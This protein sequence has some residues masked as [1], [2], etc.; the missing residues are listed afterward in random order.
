MRVSPWAFVLNWIYW[1]AVSIIY[2]KKDI[3]RSKNMLKHMFFAIFSFLAF[4][5]VTFWF[6]SYNWLHKNNQKEFRTFITISDSIFT[7]STV[8]IDMLWNKSS[9]KKQYFLA[10]FILIIAYFLVYFICI[11]TVESEIYAESLID[12]KKGVT[13]LWWLL[14]LAIWSGLTL[15]MI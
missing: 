12:S 9:F 8:T 15:L 1:F 14:I 7:F 6:V 3:R 2:F 10:S 4:E 13:Q 5:F 11:A